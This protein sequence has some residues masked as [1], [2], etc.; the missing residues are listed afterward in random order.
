MTKVKRAVT[1]ISVIVIFLVAIFLFLWLENQ[2]KNT[3]EAT[4]KNDS[5]VV[6]VKE[7]SNNTNI[8]LAENNAETVAEIIN[9]KNDL[10]SENFTIKQVG[11]G[12]NIAI[13][14]DDSDQMPIEI[15]NVRS[16]I[17]LTKNSEESKLVVTWESNKLT[18]SEISYAKN[19]GQKTSVIRESGYGFSHSVIIPDLEQGAGYI[20]QIKSRDRWNNSHT[21][22]YFGVYAGSRAVSVFELVGKAFNDI[23]GWAISGK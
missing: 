13:A 22:G 2:S 8:L 6:L 1:I 10:S 9:Q 17:F 11:F 20:Y 21:S 4:E 14:A 7:N 23:F 5:G 3:P 16:D 12:G 18:Y 19:N 15:S